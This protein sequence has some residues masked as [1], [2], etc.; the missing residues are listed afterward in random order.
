MDADKK[1]FLSLLTAF[2][3]ERPA[4]EKP[5][6]A[7]LEETAR[8]ARL[9]AVE[10]I[11]GYMVRRLP[12]EARPGEKLQKYFADAFFSTIKR[13]TAAAHRANHMMEMLSAAGLPH[14]CLK[15]YVVRDCYP[16][17]ELRTFGDVD[18]FL[19]QEDL[20]PAC[21][22]A[23][24]EGYT[25]SRG[26]ALECSVR[27]GEEYY[28]FHAQM[29][30][31]EISDSTDLTDYFS[32]IWDYAVPLSGSYTYTLEAEQ[33]LLYLF[34][35][36]A[37]HL[38]YG[39]AGVRMFLD[40]AAFIKTYAHLDWGKLHTE[41]EKTGLSR[42]AGRVLFFCREWLELPLPIRVE[43]MPEP[44]AAAFL[45]FVLSGGVFGASSGDAPEVAVRRSIRGGG[46]AAGAV[47]TARLRTL[48]PSYEEMR[49]AYPFIN[50]KNYL[51]P[52]AWMKRAL[53]VFSPKRK[54]IARRMHALSQVAVDDRLLAEKKLFDFLGLK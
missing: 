16:V 13:M 2:L 19:K 47:W 49:A 45:E 43:D 44:E 27:R 35:H 39:G 46:G 25:V 5:P 24:E 30:E 11:I 8:L 51:L 18:L 15:G 4:P 42:F 3:W 12:P 53:C 20:E 41:L 29:V 23:R 36:L 26:N 40:I 37:K 14:I 34:V 28:E 10:G 38:C 31:V 50:G 22:V 17:P 52:L 7:S 1:Y 6:E 32:D 48:F 21:R 54:R 33:H 9:H